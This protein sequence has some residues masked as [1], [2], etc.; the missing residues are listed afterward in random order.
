MSDLQARLQRL[1]QNKTDPQYQQDLDSSANT[2]QVAK[3]FFVSDEYFSLKTRIH[4]QLTKTI[5]LTLMDSID[6][7]VLH[8][9]I[10]KIT[11]NIL[12][13]ESI[14]VIPLNQ[15]EKKKGCFRKFN[16][17]CLALGHWNH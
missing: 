9:E 12:L 7:E 13:N 8:R 17:R 4:D 5:D 2:M 15:R 11:E 1:S 16:T 14:E 6:H 10:R 3:D